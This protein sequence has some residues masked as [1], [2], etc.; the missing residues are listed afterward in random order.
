MFHVAMRHSVLL[1]VLTGI[2]WTIGCG[3]AGPGIE[4]F[5]VSGTVKLGA[6]LISNGE[7]RFLADDGSRVD[8][9]PIVNGAFQFEATEGKKRVEIFATREIAGKT[10]ESA[11]SPGETEPA[12][13][14]Y[15]PSKYNTDSKLE[16]QVSPGDGNS[17]DF[18]LE[19]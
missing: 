19:P 15:I 17:Y 7:I 16:A 14:M 10:V 8:A 11:V 9:G 3:G 6:D 12:T 1:V 5:P 18:P 13:E 2:S 4:R